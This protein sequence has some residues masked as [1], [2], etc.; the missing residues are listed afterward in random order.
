[1]FGRLALPVARRALCST[2]T[3]TKLPIIVF[4]YYSE[5]I[6]YLVKWLK[7][8]CSGNFLKCFYLVFFA[9]DHAF[10]SV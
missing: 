10:V 4:M 3:K 2:G 5:S 7:A 1:M 9:T 6:Q 8:I